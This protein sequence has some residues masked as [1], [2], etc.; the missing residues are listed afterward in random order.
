MKHLLIK[1]R[2]IL[3]NKGKNNKVIIIKDGKEYVN[4]WMMVP[5]GLKIN[6]TGN[7]NVVKLILPM[8]ITKSQIRISSN[9]AYVE[10]GSSEHINGLSIVCQNGTNQKCTIGHNNWIG[11]IVVWIA[12]DNTRVIVGNDC[13]ISDGIFF[14]ATDFHSIIDIGKKEIVNGQRH[15]LEIG[16]HCWLGHK[17]ILTKNAKI[18]DNTI[19]G[20]SSI[21]TKEFDE[22]YTVIVGNPAKVV[23]HNVLFNASEIVYLQKDKQLINTLCNNILHN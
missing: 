6:I 3:K 21:V 17:A 19:I 12:N 18:P 4:R 13:L 8:K 22:P 7:D 11:G 14:E 2:N 9:N 1:L 23:K 15:A 10:I 20:T 16:S 5:N